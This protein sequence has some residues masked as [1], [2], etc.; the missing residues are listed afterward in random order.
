MG[1]GPARAKAKAKLPVAGTSRKHE[2]S[3]ERQ[4]EKRLAE[5]LAQQT[6]TSEILRVISRAQ[7][8]VQPVFDTIAESA[9]GLLGAWSVLVLLFD[10]VLL[11]LGATRGGLPDSERYQRERFPMRLRPDHL[12]ARCILE[13]APQ[14]DPDALADPDPAHRAIARRRGFAAFLTVPMLRGGEAVGEI[15]VT[16]AVAGPFVDSEIALLQTFA[17]Q[18]V[19]AIQNA[20]LFREIEDKSRQLEA[21]TRPGSTCCPSSTTSST[22]PRS[23]P[24]GW[25][26][27]WRTST[28][29]PPSTTR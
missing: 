12:L 11:H 13:R 2:G 4:L 6:A 10:G 1:R 5:A 24:G 17:D 26:W 9:L 21:S 25:S 23:R 14:Q 18:A 27:N 28:C 15:V 3:R 19:I 8:D 22:S 16:R 20:R 7:T 29:R